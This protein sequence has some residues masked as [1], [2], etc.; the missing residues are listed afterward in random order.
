MALTNPPLY[1]K[2]IFTAIPVTTGA[3]T[4]DTNVTG[5]VAA[6]TVPSDG[7]VKFR[8]VRKVT[9][10]PLAQV[11]TATRQKVYVAKSA[12]TSVLG[13][14]RDRLQATMAAF[15]ENIST[16]EID[17]NYGDA[18]YVDL[19]PGD[20]FYVASGV[21]LTAGFQWEIQAEDY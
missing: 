7:S 20:V 15:N 11:T 16:P 1:S 10:K 9:V 2:T 14:L 3:K 6:F 5:A 13:L 21:A 12:A 18:D 4:S 8:R 19:Q 17:F